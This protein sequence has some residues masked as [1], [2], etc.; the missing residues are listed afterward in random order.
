MQF[1][2]STGKQVSLGLKTRKRFQTNMN[3]EIAY[4]IGALR[5]GN[6]T[7]IPEQGIYRIRFYQKNNAWLQFIAE[8]IEREFGKKASFYFDERHAVWCLSLTSK[9]VF[10]ELSKLAEFTGDQ[11]TWLTPSRILNGSN[12]VKEAY[13][14]GFFD[15]EGSINSFEKT[16]LN[17]PQ[18]NIR[19]YFAQANQ[20]VLEE[21][22]QIISESGIR[23]GSVCGPY[24]K[25]GTLTEMYALNIHGT[26]QVLK[27]YDS[28]GS[29]HPEKVFRF[30]LLK[31]ANR[32]N[33]DSSVASTRSALLSEGKVL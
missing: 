23:C 7:E 3:E 19:I 11:S 10:Q 30:E 16:T 12:E 13:V 8:I 5:D 14:R 32:G 6:L 2:W 9:K 28:F 15:A 26:F 22:R 29:S 17:I 1:H 33:K 27:F 20:P 31:Y 21:V 24:V 4:L 18:K 25:K